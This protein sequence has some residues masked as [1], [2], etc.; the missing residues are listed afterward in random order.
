VIFLAEEES[1]INDTNWDFVNVLKKVS[2]HNAVLD[3]FGVNGE[4]IGVMLTEMSK[5][6]SMLRP[7]TLNQ[8][9]KKRYENV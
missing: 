9:V 2:T 1:L 3:T 4:D 6:Y 8:V 5:Y 7:I